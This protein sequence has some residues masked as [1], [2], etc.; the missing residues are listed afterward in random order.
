M[1]LRPLPAWLSEL[2][3]RDRIRI[4]NLLKQSPRCRNLGT[5][6][7]ALAGRALCVDDMFADSGGKGN[8]EVWCCVGAQ[9][10]T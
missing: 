4:F 7:M 2:I 5:L 3:L 9:T 8:R 10:C 1:T 6:A